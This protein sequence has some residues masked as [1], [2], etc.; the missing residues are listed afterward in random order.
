MRFWQARCAAWNC[1]GMA[2]GLPDDFGP[3]PDDF[4]AGAPDDRDAGACAA[5]RNPTVPF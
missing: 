4:A 1:G 2:G 5:I 3:L